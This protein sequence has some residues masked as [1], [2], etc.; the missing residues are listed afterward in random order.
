[1]RFFVLFASCCMFFF[2]GFLIETYR[3]MPL[4]ALAIPSPAPKLKESPKDWKWKARNSFQEDLF[5]NGEFRGSWDFPTQSFS[6]WTAE[7]KWSLDQTCPIS[8]P[9]RDQTIVTGCDVKQAVGQA[10]QCSVG[11]VPVTKEEAIKAIGFPCPDCPNPS[12]KSP[13]AGG[14]SYLIVVSSNAESRKVVEKEWNESP[15]FQPF[16]DHTAFWSVGPDHWSLDAGFPRDGERILYQLP[17]R[18]IAHSQDSLDTR[19]LAEALRKADPRYD[20][21]RDPDLSATC[22]WWGCGDSIF[23]PVMGTWIFGCVIFWLWILIRGEGGDQ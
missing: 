11:G 15:S 6:A 5:L 20:P 22:P 8:P 2:A 21:K 23:I 14:R 7:G 16:R 18:T 19:K 10:E 4:K 12:K 1:M 9:I 3:S 17:D 13:A